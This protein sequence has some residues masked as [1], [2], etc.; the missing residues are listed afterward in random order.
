MDKLEYLEQRIARLEEKVFGAAAIPPNA[1]PAKAEPPP[2]PPV[3]PPPVP[4]TCYEIVAVNGVR[5]RAAPYLKAATY[6]VVM[7]RTQ[8]AVTATHE[9]EGYI[10]AQGWRDAGGGKWQ[11]GFFAVG[12]GGN[13]W[14]RVC[15]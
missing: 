3:P 8:I 4:E 6:A 10:W 7:P 13:V 11:Y 9:S 2:P 5:F 12:Q 14:A 1:P 15:G